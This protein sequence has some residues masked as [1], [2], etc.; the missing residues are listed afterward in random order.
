MAELGEGNVSASNWALS[1][2]WQMNVPG[3]SWGDKCGPTLRKSGGGDSRRIRR[4]HPQLLHRTRA[5]RSL[6]AS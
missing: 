2:S 4:S 5:S 1:A 3:Q 6:G